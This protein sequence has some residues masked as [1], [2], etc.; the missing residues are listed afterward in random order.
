MKLTYNEIITA[1][2]ALKKLQDKPIPVKQ[3]IVIAHLIRKFTDLMNDFATVRDGLKTRYGVNYVRDGDMVNFASEIEG[4]AA[5]FKDELNE[6]LNQ[7]I[8]VV[9]TKITLPD[10]LEVEPSILVALEKF[11]NIGG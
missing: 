10:N 4:N 8:E 2:D 7:E 1:Q 11:I 9:F 5:K 6:L 3:S